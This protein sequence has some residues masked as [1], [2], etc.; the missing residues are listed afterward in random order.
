[1]LNG[2]EEGQVRMGE[3]GRDEEVASSKKRCKNQYPIY[4]QNGGKITKIDTLFMTKTA[5]EHTC[6]GRTYLY[7]PYKGVSPP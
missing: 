4:D 2:V 5:E 6:W 3:G 7:R 1:M